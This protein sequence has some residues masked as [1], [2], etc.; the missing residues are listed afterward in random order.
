MGKKVNHTTLT[1]EPK[2]ITVEDKDEINNR[3]GLYF[4]ELREV[5]GM[6]QHDLGVAI[7]LSDEI[8]QQHIYKY[9]KGIIRIPTDIAVKISKALNVD[10]IFKGD[11]IIL[12]PR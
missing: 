1:I 9:E 7:G 4:K 8:A 3:I 6:S 10:L 12:I 5:R 11:K 2:I